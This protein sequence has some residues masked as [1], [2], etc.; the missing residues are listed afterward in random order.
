MASIVNDNGHNHSFNTA[1]N[2][3]INNVV[4][5]SINALGEVDHYK[6]TFDG[7]GEVE[8]IL[9]APETAEYALILYEGT[10]NNASFSS[11]GY[12]SSDGEG[13]ISLK[14]NVTAGT[15]Y[16]VRITINGNNY[17]PNYAMYSL[18]FNP[19]V[20][21]NIT[22][23]LSETVIRDNEETSINCTPYPIHAYNN[24]EFSTLNNNISISDNLVTGLRRGTATISAVDSI[25]GAIA[26]VNILVR[27]GQSYY[28]DQT[29]PGYENIPLGSTNIKMHGCGIC[30][31]AM[32][33]LYAAKSTSPNAT[34]RRGAVEAIVN[35]DST[36]DIFN[37]DGNMWRKNLNTT[38]SFGGKTLRLVTSDA[39]NFEES[40]NDG[41]L[42]FI[43]IHVGN[44]SHFVLIDG[45][46]ESYSS[47]TETDTD[48]LKK[49]L[50]IDPNGGISRSL[51]DAVSDKLSDANMTADPD[52]IHLDSYWRKSLSVT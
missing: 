13:H 52:I 42:V 17:L 2:V 11:R 40:V 7:N 23:T 25:S 12:G 28:I 39:S 47:L 6:I 44:E 37:A 5:G 45:I 22:I 30:C 8:F 18:R 24:V 3:T 20:A 48:Y 31:I 14:Y 50:V 43:R 33:L 9:T 36:Y 46:D 4:S 51:Y 15:T 26:S 27:M 49:F 34:D 38:I 19:T 10:N 32:G 1:Q 29:T 41:N 35:A 16:I 21:S